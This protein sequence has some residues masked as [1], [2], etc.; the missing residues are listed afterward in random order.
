MVTVLAGVAAAMVVAI[1]VAVLLA[2]ATP[3]WW[4]EASDTEAGA[5]RAERLENGV[6]TAMSAVRPLGETWSIALDEE[7]VNAWLA[8]RLGK[9]LESRGEAWP[10]A[11]SRP[12]VRLEEGLVTV[13]AEVS[14]GGRV[15][16]L[17]VRPR[18]EHGGVWVEVEAVRVGRLPVPR[19]VAL[20]FLPG[21]GGSV[22]A[23]MRGEGPLAAEAM[24]R[25]DGVR[26]V[27]V[28]G[29]TPREGRLEVEAVTEIGP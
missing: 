12:R 11:L 14:S 5:A 7:D 6:A 29:V 25:V 20:A 23:A 22:A 4:E 8:E 13:A 26:R 9:W 28:L 18:V 3:G 17:G 27:R 2:G 10:G 21:G 19:D 1:I 15:V 24:F 16:S